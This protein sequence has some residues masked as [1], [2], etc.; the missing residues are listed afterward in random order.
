MKYST[1]PRIFSAGLWRPSPL[2]LYTRIGPRNLPKVIYEYPARN[3]REL[4]KEALE[5][6]MC[7]SASYDLGVR[8][9]HDFLV[10]TEWRL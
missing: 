8:R 3:C 9:D 1:L 5:S 2:I 4:K 6:T 10:Y 7:P